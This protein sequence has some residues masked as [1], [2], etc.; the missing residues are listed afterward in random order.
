MSDETL[1]EPRSAA[2]VRAAMT[3]NRKSLCGYFS[4]RAEIIGTLY[5]AALSGQ[6][7]LLVGDPGTAKSA[8][9]EAWTTQWADA[10]YWSGLMTRQTVESDVLCHL[11]VEQFAQHSRYVY[12]YEG[13]APPAHFAFLDECF[14]SP[15]GLLN[16]LL[17]W[18][19]ERVVKRRHAAGAAFASP[20]VTCIGASNEFGE[21]DSTRALDDRFL[22]RHKPEYIQD[23]AAKIQFLRDRAARKAPPTLEPLSLA[24]L[25]AAQEAAAALPIDDAIFAALSG[26]QR[27]LVGASINVSD[28]RIGQCLAVLQAWAWLEGETSVG[29]EHLDVLR[30]VLWYRPEDRPAVDAAIG[31]IDKG[32]IGE[33]RSIAEQA[34]EPFYTARDGADAGPESLRAYHNGCPD[35]MVK[36]QEAAEKIKQRFGGQVPE[37]VKVRSKQYLDEL[38][39]AF[40]AAREDAQKARLGL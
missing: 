24:E 26:L 15:G 40:K 25:Q 39:E 5:V 36:L 2:E 16:S 23:D 22:L 8:L 27:T 34:L 30:H 19:N 38:R 35:F 21:D 28:R 14:K 1:I 11:D 32:L 4:E 31:A 29:P 7:V 10:V 20:L 13:H 37:R 33:I 6:H 3:R 12:V 18:L 9:T 17:G